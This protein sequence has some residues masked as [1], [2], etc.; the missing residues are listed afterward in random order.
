MNMDG[1]EKSSS[2][3][4]FPSVL[5]PEIFS[6]AVNESGAWT[7]LTCLCCGFTVLGF[8][9]C[10]SALG[11]ESPHTGKRHCRLGV[12][13]LSLYTQRFSALAEDRCYFPVVIS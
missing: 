3:K 1:V 4:R 5:R 6:E 2:S 12:T 10:T 7:V 9:H 13:V 11:V 8:K